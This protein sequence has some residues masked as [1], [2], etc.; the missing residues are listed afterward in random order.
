MTAPVGRGEG[1]A[2]LAAL[3]AVALGAVALHRL[4]YSA[5]AGEAE[6]VIGAASHGN[7]NALNALVLLLAPLLIA[8]ALLSGAL[9]RAGARGD[10]ATAARPATWPRGLCLGA[11]ML[12]MFVGQELLE[13]GLSHNPIAPRDGLLAVLPWAALL[14]APLGALASL[15]LDRLRG[16]AEAI[17][18]RVLGRSALVRL[19]GVARG[20]CVGPKPTRVV[21]RSPLAF[22]LARRPPP[23]FART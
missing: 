17:V 12:A 20:C 6:A 3:G 11:A 7:L 10:S 9:L 21:R 8:A 15:A 23:R 14:A 22:G 5:S 1:R 18:A 16:G 13:V 4:A 2:I 19:G